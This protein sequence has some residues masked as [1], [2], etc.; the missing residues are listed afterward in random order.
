MAAPNPPN[1]AGVQPNWDNINGLGGITNGLG[2]IVVGNAVRPIL[3]SII[4]SCV[5]YQSRL[6]MDPAN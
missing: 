1:L 6:P 3:S 2:Q 4:L 5:D